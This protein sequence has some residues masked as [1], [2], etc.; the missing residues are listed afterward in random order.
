MASWRCRC[1][2]LTSLDILTASEARALQ[3]GET[4]LHRIVGELS[5]DGCAIEGLLATLEADPALNDSAKSPN[6]SK[7][8][9]L[10]QSGVP[11]PIRPHLRWLM[12]ALVVMRSPAMLAQLLAC[13]PRGPQHPG[14]P[15]EAS[16][17]ASAVAALFSLPIPSDASRARALLLA[18]WRAEL[19]REREVHDEVGIPGGVLPSNRS[20]SALFAAS[21]V[22]HPS[23]LLCQIMRSQLQRLL[24]ARRFLQARC[25]GVLEELL[26]GGGADSAAAAAAAPPQQ[27]PPAAASS[28]SGGTAQ[29]TRAQLAA[30]D[31]AARE[32]LETSYCCE[33]LL[34]S[35][36]E[37]AAGLPIL[38]LSL[39]SRVAA[40]ATCHGLDAAAL[41][42]AMIVGGWLAP[43]LGA[44]SLNGITVLTAKSPR[45]LAAS[46]GSVAG[47]LICAA[48]ASAQLPWS[49]NGILANDGG[50]MPPASAM[51]TWF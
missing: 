4:D 31:D 14:S 33:S 36:R 6:H 37:G 28:S 2:A 18:L 47:I 15:C 8:A 30:L 7:T 12:R 27:P 26:D 5:E 19:A 1:D 35:L 49:F 13:R 46:L 20:E 41:V 32:E 29:Q 42:G 21:A 11:A 17:V 48:A 38:I 43:A 34:A 50:A 24:P 45:E 22:L 44:P 10:P 25:A 39:A 23:G 51:D 9:S 40:F 16:T 3:Q